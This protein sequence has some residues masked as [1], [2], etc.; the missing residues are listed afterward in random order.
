MYWTGQD[1]PKPQPTYYYYYRSSAEVEM[2]AYALL[3]ILHQSDDNV[4]TNEVMDIIRWLSKQR[5]SYGGFSSTQ[6]RVVILKSWSRDG[7]TG[8]GAAI[9]HDEAKRY[10]RQNEIQ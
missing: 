8:R 3:A 2:T 9:F 5:N 6:V 7:F 4:V 10:W 1:K